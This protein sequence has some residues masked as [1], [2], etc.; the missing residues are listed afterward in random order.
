MKK[1]S[2]SA[3]IIPRKLNFNKFLKDKKIFKIYKNFE[4]NFENLKNP[5]KVAVS[6]SGGSDSLA[7]SFL[8]LCYKFKKKINIHASFYLINHGLR[9]NSYEEAISVKNIL[10]LNEI[11]LKILHWKGKKPKSNIQSLAR[12][13]RYELLFNECTKSNIKVVLFGHHQED[14]YETFFSRLLRGSGTEGLSSFSKIENRFDHKNN[15]I[16]VFRPLL[17]LN[18]QDLI[19]I[20]KKV[21]KFYIKDPSNEQDRFQRVRIRKLILNLKNEGLDLK[22]LN[23]TIN[24]LASTTEA[25]N[26]IVEYNIR[27]NV[28]FLLKNKYLINSKFFLIPKE[29]VFRSLSLLFRKISK[30]HYPPRGKKMINLIKDLNYKKY[31]KL[32]LGGTIIEKIHNSVLV[33]KEKTK[34]H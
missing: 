16:R 20:S 23:L 13:K 27:E 24:N 10:R 8:V 2:L 14:I 34:K 5:N 31:T 7:L 21:F 19:Y 3:K 4:K 32:T 11:D 12:K 29:I 33:S 28:A 15:K 26:E 6:V 25:I 17:N 22:K 30:K 18:K 9:N 1:K